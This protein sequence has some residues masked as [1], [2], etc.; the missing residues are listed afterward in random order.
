M[1]S[2]MNYL[3]RTQSTETVGAMT[4]KRLAASR[5]GG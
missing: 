4:A 1:M 5:Q 2:V 3:R